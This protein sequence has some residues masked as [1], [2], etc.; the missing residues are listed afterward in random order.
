MSK[1]GDDV[2]V[3]EDDTVLRAMLRIVLE[4]AG[5]SVRFFADAESLLEAARLKRPSCVLLDYVLPELS[6][7]EIMEQLDKNGCSAPKVIMSGY[8]SIAVAVKAIRFGAADFIE[9]P[10]SRS[11]LLSVIR[12][13]IDH[14]KNAK[15]VE[16]FEASRSPFGEE[17][18]QREKEVLDRLLEGATTGEIA[19]A[20]RISPRTV[21]YH[22]AR[23]LTK[24]GVKRTVDLV[25]R[26][27]AQREPAS[28]P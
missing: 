20:L 3:I 17:L 22:R 2:Y 18:S 12:K 19:Q 25:Q 11:A 27:L 15:M 8:A 28:L 21:E 16:K 5:Y 1:D 23:M 14:S 10:F 9:K 24:Y 26:V 13:A 7:L 4:E 6:G